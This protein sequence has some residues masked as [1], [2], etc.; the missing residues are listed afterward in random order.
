[1][2][3]TLTLVGHAV[4]AVPLATWLGWR[5]VKPFLVC[6]D[7]E[8]KKTSRDAL[9]LLVFEGGIYVLLPPL[10]L[11][12]NLQLNLLT[13][14]LGIMFAVGLLGLGRACLAWVRTRGA[15]SARRG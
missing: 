8:R 10:V 11:R 5:C 2:D 15:S 9:L 14:I 1:M 13:S 7:V 3:D 6:R 4:C 12:G